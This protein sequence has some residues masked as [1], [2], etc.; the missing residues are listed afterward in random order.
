MEWMALKVVALRI[1]ERDGLMNQSV[2]DRC[3]DILSVS[4][5]TLLA[6]YCSRGN[7]PGLCIRT[8]LEKCSSRY[9]FSP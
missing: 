9:E 7:K 2:G 8:K 4:Q 3:G 6:D 5:F 1:F